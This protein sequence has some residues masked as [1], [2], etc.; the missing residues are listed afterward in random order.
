[1]FQSISN[2]NIHQM[3]N[4]VSLSLI[5]ASIILLTWAYSEY[6]SKSKVF[7]MMNIFGFLLITFVLGIINYKLK[8]Y[9]QST[10]QL[11][12]EHYRLV[13]VSI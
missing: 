5:T 6:E 4:C 3:L 8:L 9:R 12:N 10:S 1:M 2:S 11:D 7:I 13:G